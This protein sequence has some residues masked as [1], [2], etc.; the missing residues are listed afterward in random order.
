V[1]HTEQVYQAGG[2]TTYDGY[3]T[4]MRV[5]DYVALPNGQNA[6]ALE[7]R[8]VF[9]SGG[10]R[11]SELYVLADA[12]GVWAV[13]YW[14]EEQGIFLKQANTGL[15]G[16]TFTNLA[17]IS[18]ALHGHSGVSGRA[19]GKTNADLVLYDRPYLLWSRNWQPG[20]QWATLTNLSGA[21]RSYKTWI[22]QETAPTYLGNEPAVKLRLDLEVNPAGY[23]NPNLQAWQWLNENG[24]RFANYYAASILLQHPITGHTVVGTYTENTRLISEGF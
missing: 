16:R 6:L 20:Q 19:S 17:E 14:G 10:Q 3:T 8:D 13:G 5:L 1:Y 4:T 15:Q 22:G 24:L 21:M 11:W 23:A 18:N 7:V 9:R 12:T 2:Y